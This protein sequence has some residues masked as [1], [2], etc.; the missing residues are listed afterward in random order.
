MAFS[1][2]EVARRIDELVN[3]KGI[4]RDPDLYAIVPSPTL[5]AWRTAKQIPRVITL[6]NIADFLGVSVQ[7]LIL[8]KEENGLSDHEREL[9]IAFNELND[10][11]KDAAL[12]MIKGLAIHSSPNTEESDTELDD[13]KET[14]G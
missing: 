1:G 3:L 9:L 8:G 5:S 2:P 7:W 4:R 6:C 12:R 14:A 11:E 13:Q 10:T